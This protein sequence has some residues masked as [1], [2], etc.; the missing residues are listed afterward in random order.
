[1]LHAAGWCFLAGTLIFSGFLAILALSGIKWLG[2]IVPIGGL[3]MLV[4]WTILAA[5]GLQLSAAGQ[6]AE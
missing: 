3:L 2:A 6:P 4:G 1:M 5:V